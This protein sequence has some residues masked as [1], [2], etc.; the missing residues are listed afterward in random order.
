MSFRLDLVNRAGLFRNYASW[1]ESDKNW[2]DLGHLNVAHSL[3]SI[4]YALERIYSLKKE[5]VDQ[6]MLFENDYK[7]SG[8]E[9]LFRS[10]SI[11]DMFSS[12][13]TYLLSMRLAQNALL[14][15]LGKK[16]SMTIPQSMNSIVDWKR[17]N[18]L[19]KEVFNLIAVYWEKSGFE[20]KQYRD[21][22]QHYGLVARDAWIVKSNEGVSVKVYLPDNPAIQSESKFTFTLKRD[23]FAYADKAF[24]LFH[25]FVNN[26]SVSLGYEKERDFDNN[27]SM[28]ISNGISV[29]IMSDPYQKIL[30]ATE[31][32]ISSGEFE[33]YVN[34]EGFDSSTY[35][36]IN[37]RFPVRHRFH[38]ELLQSGKIKSIDKLPQ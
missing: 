35:I 33:T 13:S 38:R 34:S 20:L 25:T 6:Y 10:P 2:A 18:T 30:C 23:A 21:L 24:E 32:N 29:H 4:V 22:D 8:N 16:L 26:L 9:I 27:I 7:W 11:Y 14:N 12:Y 37:E 19:P 5:C 36:K 17:K 1:H 31:T 15:I 28:P 3:S